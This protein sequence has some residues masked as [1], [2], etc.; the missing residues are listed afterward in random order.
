MRTFDWIESQKWQN[1]VMTEMAYGH[2]NAWNEL[3]LLLNKMSLMN[4]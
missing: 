1:G 2:S 3:Q 4:K